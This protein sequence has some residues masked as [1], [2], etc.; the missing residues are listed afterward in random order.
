MRLIWIVLWGAVQLCAEPSD[1]WKKLEFLL[2]DWTGFAGEKDTPIGS[3]EGSYSFQPELEQKIIVRH[4]KSS[5]SSGVRHED[6]MV[7]YLDA[8]NSSPR[9][10]Y[11]DSEGHVIRYTLAFPASERVVFESEV[12]VGPR[13]RLTYW[14]EGASPGSGYKPYMNWTSR[15]RSSTNP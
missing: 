9:A 14:L 8:P 10:I 2:G 4:N 6:L 12:S 7:I 13:Y 1:N 11:F 15:R 3:G 5:Y